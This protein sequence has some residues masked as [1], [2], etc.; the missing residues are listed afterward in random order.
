MGIAF[1]TT[2]SKSMTRQDDAPDPN[3]LLFINIID[4]V[5]REL[6]VISTDGSR[7][8]KCLFHWMVTRKIC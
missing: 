1:R 7:I 4:L 2:A 3:D 8:S 5:T 6:S